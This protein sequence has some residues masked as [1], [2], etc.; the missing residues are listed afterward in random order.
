MLLAD[1]SF[2]SSTN[3]ASGPHAGD[4]WRVIAGH[5]IQL[6][7]AASFGQ[8]PVFALSFPPSTQKQTKTN[9]NRIP[10]QKRA[11]TPPSFA[12]GDVMTNLHL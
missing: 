3:D 8:L 11:R 2:V 5:G 6:L 1:A 4:T 7:G 9:N 12:H 10:L